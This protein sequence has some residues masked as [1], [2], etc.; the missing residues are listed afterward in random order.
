MRPFGDRIG[1]G[2]VRPAS[3]FEFHYTSFPER[4]QYENQKTKKKE[5]AKLFL[6]NKNMEKQLKKKWLIY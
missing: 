5:D 4:M 2:C 1:V 6:N 3:I